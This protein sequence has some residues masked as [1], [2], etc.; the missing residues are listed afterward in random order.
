ML[1]WSTRSIWLSL[2]TVGI[3]GHRDRHVTRD[4]SNKFC[5]DIASNVIPYVLQAIKWTPFRLH[6]ASASAGLSTA[7]MKLKEQAANDSWQRDTLQQTPKHVWAHRNSLTEYQE[8]VSYRA[9][10]RQRSLY[11]PEC[12]L[13]PQSEAIRAQQREGNLDAGPARVLKQ[14]GGA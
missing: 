4:C 1:T 6:R 9:T 10:V 3:T 7:T 5:L 13:Q 8:W 11:F 14:T 2:L 12:E